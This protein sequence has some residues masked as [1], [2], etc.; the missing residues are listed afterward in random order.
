MYRKSLIY[1]STFLLV[2]CL[3]KYKLEDESTVSAY[4]AMELLDGV[5]TE[6]EENGRIIT[7]SLEES[8]LI[9]DIYSGNSSIVISYELVG[10]QLENLGISTRDFVEMDEDKRLG[11]IRFMHQDEEPYVRIANSE[12]SIGVGSKNFIITDNILRL[13]INPL[14]DLEVYQNKNEFII[15][16]SKEASKISFELDLDDLDLLKKHR[17][18]VKATSHKTAILELVSNYE[19]R[20]RVNIYSTESSYL[21]IQ[22]PIKLHY[23]V[24]D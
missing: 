20:I 5:G 10:N 11:N 15:Q 8:I 14:M 22:L 18:E 19:A 1:L 7:I 21:F 2:L 16:K 6:E 3:M 24:N 17:D 9:N 13:L 12:I 23:T 4:V